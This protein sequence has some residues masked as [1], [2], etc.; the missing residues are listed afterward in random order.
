MITV[1]KTSVSKMENAAAKAGFNLPIEQTAVWARFQSEADGRES[2][3]AL[4]VH[5][6]G[7]LLAVASLIALKTHGYIYLLSEHGPVWAATPSS[8]KESTVVHAIASFVHQSDRRIVFLRLC[9][10][11]TKGTHPVL[12]TIPYDRTVV[13]DLTGGKDQILA[14]MKKRGRYDVRH[15]IKKSPARV[16]DETSMAVKDFSPYYDVMLE[17]ASRDHFSAAPSEYYRGLLV[18]LGHDHARLY[19]ARENGKV[20]AWLIATLRGTS[21]VYYFA[22]SR[23]QARRTN[24]PDLLLFETAADLSAQGFTTFDLMGIGDDFSPTLMSLNPFKTKFS[25]QTVAIAPARD[26]ALRRGFYCLLLLAKAVRGSIRSLIHHRERVRREQALAARRRKSALQGPHNGKK[27]A[28][29][30]A[31]HPSVPSISQK[32]PSRQD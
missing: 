29:H 3:G 2:W 16:A 32:T 13:L 26:I 6:N 31:A 18:A 1:T 27:P 30:P 23:R 7:Q 22:S 5:E 15:A 8:E 25:K 10:T 20:T 11:T 12:S 28:H 21:A 17:T 14:R 19:A 9:V 4:L 24:V